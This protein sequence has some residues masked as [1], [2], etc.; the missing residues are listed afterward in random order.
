MVK[1]SVSGEELYENEAM[2][3]KRF[4]YISNMV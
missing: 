3:M 4:E 1:D 2:C